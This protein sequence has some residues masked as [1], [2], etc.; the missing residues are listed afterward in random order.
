MIRY[1]IEVNNYG[2]KDTIETKEGSWVK[3]ED[4]KH[5]DINHKEVCS[6]CGRPVK[7]VGILIAGDA[8]SICNF[9]LGLACEKVA[10]HMLPKEAKSEVPRV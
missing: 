9:C 2:G 7:D 5:L 3:Y 4:I 1:D 10:E 8:T 6:F